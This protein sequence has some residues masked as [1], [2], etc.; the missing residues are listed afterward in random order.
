[1]KINLKARFRH[2]TFVVALF[3]LL[4]VLANQIA[5]LFGVDITIYNDQITS[6]AETIFAI[7][8]MLGILID[9]TTEGISDSERA[10]N[11]DEPWKDK[12]HE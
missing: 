5:G 11:Y 2:K 7:L 9:P 12:Q 1:M 4:L 6:L 8:G 10:L 3:S